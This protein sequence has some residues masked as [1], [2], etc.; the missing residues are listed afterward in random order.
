VT[1]CLSFSLS[2]SFLTIKERKPKIKLYVLSGWKF[3]SFEGHEG[4]YGFQTQCS[5][6]VIAVFFHGHTCHADRKMM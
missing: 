2:L 5:G 6:T 3:V 1:S 4:L